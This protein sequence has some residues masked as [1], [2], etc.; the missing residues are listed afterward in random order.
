MSLAGIGFDDPPLPLPVA[1]NFN[2]ALQTAAGE[3][4]RQ[5]G[6]I[7]AY[8]WKM[9]QNEQQRVNVIF[10]TTVEHLREQGY[11]V[12]PQAPKSISADITVFSAR[13]TNK[14]L[15]AMWSAGD[16]GLVLLLC[17]MPPA[18][19]AAAKVGGSVTAAPKPAAKKADLKKPADKKTAKKKMPAAAQAKSAAPA[20]AP[21]P[22]PAEDAA[23]PLSAP[24]PAAALQP[25]PPVTEEKY[26]IPSSDQPAASG[27]V[28]PSPPLSSGGDN[29]ASPASGSDN[30]A[31]PASGVPSP[32]LSA[33]TENADPG[34]PPLSGERKPESTLVPPASMTATGGPSS[35]ADVVVPVMPSSKDDMRPY[36]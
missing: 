10:T 19:Q 27:S 3:L 23:I 31:P 32:P 13:R 11:T 12:E 9:A 1:Q 8:G 25:L 5:C 22:Q 16:L 6:A 21:A 28:A 24:D 36:R 29:M 18:D 14:E 33:T 35:P 26:A 17:E 30:A 2:I 7:E 4:G 20:I 34:T 15:L